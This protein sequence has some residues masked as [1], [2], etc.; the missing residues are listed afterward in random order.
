MCLYLA[1]LMAPL[2]S[3]LCTPMNILFLRGAFRNYLKIR[4]WSDIRCF[5]L[6]WKSIWVF[7]LRLE[8]CLLS[9]HLPPNNPNFHLISDHLLHFQIS[10][11]R[12]EDC[13]N[14]L[15][16]LIS[17]LKSSTSANI[18]YQTG[19]LSEYFKILISIY[20]ISDQILDISTDRPTDWHLGL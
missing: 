10:D 1:S 8:G 3:I 2:H 5:L 12:P 20:S 14:T 9:D 17:D 7:F 11:I 16:Y 6:I 15:L 19:R 4:R 18:W 13:L